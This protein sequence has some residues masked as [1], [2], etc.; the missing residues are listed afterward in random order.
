MF[1]KPIPETTR[2]RESFSSAQNCGRSQIEAHQTGSLVVDIYWSIFKNPERVISF[3][4]DHSGEMAWAF[5]LSSISRRPRTDGKSIDLSFLVAVR[6]RSLEL[7][8]V[9]KDSV[10]L[11]WGKKLS[12]SS[13]SSLMQMTLISVLRLSK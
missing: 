9:L 8:E 3:T 4:E 12:N 7:L 2:K 13:A 11:K 6:F 1:W 5:I 10:S